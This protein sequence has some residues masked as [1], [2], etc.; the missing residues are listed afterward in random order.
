MITSDAVEQTCAEVGNYSEAEMASEF[1]VF[2]QAEPDVC[3][4]VVEL[5]AE[6]GP[7]VQELSLFLSYMIFKNVRLNHGADLAPV[8]HEMIETAFRE[9][10]RWIEE[11]DRGRGGAAPEAILS[12]LEAETEPHLLQYIITE[13]NRTA[14]EA[15]DLTDEQKGE[16]FFV[17]KTVMSTFTRRPFERETTDTN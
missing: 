10:E 1:E 15:T 17:V 6:S 13:I 2:F 16:V 3:D 5:T 14:G 9:S 12:S 8:T 11:L 7:R 4:F